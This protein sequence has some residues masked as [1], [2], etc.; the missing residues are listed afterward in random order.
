M[1]QAK[2]SQSE[3][4]RK[5]SDWSSSLALQAT[6]HPEKVP[7]LVIDLFTLNASGCSLIQ[8]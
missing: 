2:I 8:I 4:A 6:P 3:S 1:M 7:V 5:I